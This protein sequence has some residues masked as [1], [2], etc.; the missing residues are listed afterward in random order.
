MTAVFPGRFAAQLD[1]PVVVFLIGMRI[2]RLRAFRKWLR[3][4][5]EMGPMLRTL[6]QHPNKGF[7]HFEFFFSWRTLLLVQY[8]R[9]F[10]DLERFAR[11]REEPHAGAWQR[12]I[13]DVGDDGTVGV[14]HETYLIQPGAAEA[15]YDNMPRFGLA[16]AT[17]HVPA[18][19][20]RAQARARI[21]ADDPAAVRSIADTPLPV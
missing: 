6:L 13:R 21:S 2:N 5:R 12:F 17:R 9:S 14:Y 18:T 8:W 15:I 3:V 16:A 10:D 1:E 19:G 4:F 7:L 11:S 20:S